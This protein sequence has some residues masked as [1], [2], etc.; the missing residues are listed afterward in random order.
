MNANL[1][2]RVLSFRIIGIKRMSGG[3]GKNE[4]SINETEPKTQTA[5]GLSALSII[6]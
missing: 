6:R 3:R 4:L 2:A 1:Q 5:F